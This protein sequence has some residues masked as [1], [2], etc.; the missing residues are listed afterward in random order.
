[1]LWTNSV[2]K[3]VLSDEVPG[4]VTRFSLVAAGTHRGKA[5]VDDL[6]AAKAAGEPI[7]DVVWRCV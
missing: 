7:D 4:V 3:T 6:I 1:M 2:D 5:V